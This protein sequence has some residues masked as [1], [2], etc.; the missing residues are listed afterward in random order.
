MSPE[1]GRIEMDSQPFPKEDAYPLATPI[2]FYKRGFDLIAE[3]WDKTEALEGSERGSPE[4]ETYVAWRMNLIIWTA[5]TIESFV[6][7][8]GVS[9]VGE[10]FYKDTIERQKITAKI[11]LIYGLKHC[12]CLDK[13]ESLLKQIKDLFEVRNHYVHPKTRSAEGTETASPAF[14]KLIGSKP[15]ELWELL[16]LLNDLLQDPEGARENQ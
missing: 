5:C 2:N 1:F 16:Q 6:N 14:K 7:L 12:Q 10:E 11:R 4:F 8:E 13:D 15:K 9:W 3:Q